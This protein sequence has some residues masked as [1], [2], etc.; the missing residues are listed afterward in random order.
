MSML[1]LAIPLGV[2]IGILFLRRFGTGQFCGG[3]S[4]LAC[5]LPASECKHP[6]RKTISDFVK[7]GIQTS[8]E[9][10]AALQCAIELEFSTIPPYLCAEWS[11]KDQEDPVR[12]IIHEIVIQEM[13]HMALACNMLS[14][15]GGKPS[16]TKAGF[17]AHY[18]TNGLPGGV[19]PNLKVDLL[20]LSLESLKTFMEIEYPCDGPIAAT[21]NY[22]TIGEF[23]DAIA[24]AFETLSPAFCDGI[25]MQHKFP[26]GE[27][28]A[29]KSAADAVKAIKVIKEQGEG[30]SQTPMPP[31]SLS[32]EPS[33]YYAF[34]QLVEGRRLRK[35]DDGKWRF[36]GEAMPLPAVHSFAQTSDDA[37]CAEFNQALRDILEGLERTWAIGTQEFPKAMQGMMRL[38]KQGISLVR[39]GLRPNFNP[40]TNSNERY[41]A[42]NNNQ[43]KCTGEA[44][45]KCGSA[46]GS[47]SNTT[48]CECGTEC[49]SNCATNCSG[50]CAK[51]S[52]HTKVAV[53]PEIKLPRNAARCNCGDCSC[54]TGRTSCG[55]K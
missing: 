4:S 15:I 29:I 38:R 24:K 35:G 21:E 8:D 25:Q 43:C 20:P 16:L 9:L 19:H 1:Y 30:N 51:P 50:T 11:I 34:K 10:K 49:S 23:Y 36:D 6:Q 37:A 39:R 47:S 48:N 46:C 12:D 31:E 41:T 22:A 14:A 52:Q 32:G 13:V 42:M 33:H 18:P 28:F 44:E 45:C 55:C 53:I 7:N 2:A 5:G 54:Q 3:A 26:V 27:V 40:Q 17:L